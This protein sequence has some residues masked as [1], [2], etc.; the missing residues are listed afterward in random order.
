MSYHFFAASL[1]ML[2][3][4]AVP[5]MTVDAYRGLCAEAM[6]KSDYAALE[7]LLDGGETRD[8]FVLNWRN[9]DAMIRNAVA[10]QRAVRTGTAADAAKWIRP[11]TGIE[12]F[13]ENAVAAAFQESDPM[14]REL[15][16]ARLRWT[17]VEDISGYDNF[18]AEY[19]MAYSIKLGI[20]NAIAS[21]DAEQGSERLRGM[22]RTG[23]LPKE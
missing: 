9:C 14:K 10:R 21:A 1:P 11:Q 12:V 5:P 2:V 15:A 7:A 16:L 3:L 18:S 22:V 17:K 6:N 8:P 13:V 4:N 23:A 20:L 19:L